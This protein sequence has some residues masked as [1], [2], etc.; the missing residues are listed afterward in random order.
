MRLRPQHWRHF[1][2]HADSTPWKK[3]LA[4]ACT[5]CTKRRNVVKQRGNVKSVKLRYVYFIVSKN[6]TVE[7][8]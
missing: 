1:P 5:V 6:I 2:K 3:D 7:D 8:Y 4:R